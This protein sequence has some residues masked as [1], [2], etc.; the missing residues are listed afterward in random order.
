MFARVRPNV[1]TTSAE[2]GSTLAKVG[3]VLMNFGEI[4]IV[5]AHA[6]GPVRSS[7]VYRDR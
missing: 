3:P 5:W 2:L 6:F 7:K 4:A 1:G